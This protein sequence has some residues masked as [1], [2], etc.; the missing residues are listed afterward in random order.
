VFDVTDREAV[1]GAAEKLGETVGVGGL[2]G[3]VNNAGTAVTGPLALQPLEDVRAQFE[4]NVLGLV[5][6]TR[7]FLPLLG[8]DRSRSDA[9]GRIVNISS[10]GGNVASPFVGAYAGTKHAVEGLSDALRREL[11]PYG[12]DVIVVRPGAV[13]TEIWAKGATSKDLYAGTDYQ[14]PLERFEAYANRLAGGGYS[15]EEF[16]RLVL[17]AFKAKRPRTR[18]AIVR[19]RLADWVLPTLLPDRWLDRIVGRTVGLA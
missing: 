7:A 15:P 3:L 17:R 12:I 10:V 1:L 16:R 19:G 2:I 5:S 6:V 9:P 14:E 4:A 13:K 11:M 8:M 18:Y